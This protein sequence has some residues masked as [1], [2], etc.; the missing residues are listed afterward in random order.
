MSVSHE[1][2][3]YQTS[4]LT[5]TFVGGKKKKKEK[6]M[7]RIQCVITRSADSKPVITADRRCNSEIDCIERLLKFFD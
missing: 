3:S 7:L 6:E 1:Y 5:V 2:R 4:Q